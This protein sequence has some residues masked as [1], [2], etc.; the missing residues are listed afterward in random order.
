M[1]LMALSESVKTQLMNKIAAGEPASVAFN[2]I[3]IPFSAGS[4]TIEFLLDGDVVSTHT[5]ERMV[6]GDTIYLR[7]FTGNIPVAIEFTP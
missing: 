2:E 7:G 4:I 1:A 3:R 6:V 5:L